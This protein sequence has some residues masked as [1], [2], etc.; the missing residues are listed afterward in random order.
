MSETF[1]SLNETTL[2]FHTYR[3]KT[4]DTKKN[5]NKSVKAWSKD[6]SHLPVLALPH[7]KKSKATASGHHRTNTISTRVKS[8]SSACTCVGTAAT[9][10]SLKRKRGE[11]ESDDNDNND[12]DDEPDVPTTVYGGLQDEDDT[13]EEQAALASPLKAQE[14][15]QKSQVSITPAIFHRILSYN[16]G[17]Q[18][19]IIIEPGITAQTG[20][21]KRLGNKD[22]PDGA[23][24]GGKWT[25][26]FKQTFLRYLGASNENIWDLEPEATVSVLQA[27]WNEVYK[28]NKRA[29]EPE[30]SFVVNKGDAVYQTVKSLLSPL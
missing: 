23:T 10:L 13:L 8:V 16:H 18:A 30:I 24:N 14:A 12:D 15:A 2:F 4:P 3:F 6:V 11:I 17:S 19:N 20:F 29:G 26:T 27:I 25:V 22:L 28:G 21:L 1:L 7:G 5:I 9:K